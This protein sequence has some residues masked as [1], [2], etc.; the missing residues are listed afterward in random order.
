MT[1]KFGVRNLLIRFLKKDLWA[2]IPFS[3]IYHRTL[4]KVIRISEKKVRISHYGF[5]SNIIYQEIFI[6][7]VFLRLWKTL[8]FC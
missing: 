7:V 3:C 5:K 8:D 4:E 2:A 1:L 6:Q